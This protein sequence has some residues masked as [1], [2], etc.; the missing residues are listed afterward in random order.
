M[1]E[2]SVIAGIGAGF[3]FIPPNKRPFS[4]VDLTLSFPYIVDENIPTWLLIVVSL[5]APAGII[6]L[7]CLIFVPGPMVSRGT[8]KTLIWRRK[9]WEWN[10]KSFS[11]AR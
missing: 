8:P 6:F 1:G 9:F 4:L 11:S 7:V 5:V 10:S 2:N 3:N